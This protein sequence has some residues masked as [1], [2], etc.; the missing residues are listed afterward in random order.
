MV[1]G[2]SA[3]LIDVLTL[4]EALCMHMGT[5]VC[6]MNKLIDMYLLLLRLR[7]TSYTLSQSSGQGILTTALRWQTILYRNVY[8]GLCMHA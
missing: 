8:V 3:P 6:Y 4:G 2:P 7:F 1:Q 5:I